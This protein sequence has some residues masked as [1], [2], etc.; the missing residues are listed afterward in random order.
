MCNR[1]VSLCCSYRAAF[2]AGRCCRIPRRNAP[3]GWRG[4]ADH[5]RWGR[6][7]RCP[8]IPGWRRS[9]AWWKPSNSL[10]PT[11]AST[12]VGITGKI[13]TRK[14]TKREKR[15]DQRNLFA[16]ATFSDVKSCVES[17]S[18]WCCLLWDRCAAPAAPVAP[19]HGP[20]AFWTALGS[21][22]FPGGPNS[23]SERGEPHLDPRT[24]QTVVLKKKKK[25]TKWSI[26]I[27]SVLVLQ[28]QHCENR[29]HCVSSYLNVT[30]QKL[31]I[32]FY[33]QS[34]NTPHLYA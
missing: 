2:L 30:N 31:Q 24:T 7:L 21:A 9:A 1:N 22:G 19:A 15:L 29:L 5:R 18:I 27:I 11:Q 32:S 16:H 28:Y 13:A 3:F 8:S 10:P 17:P 6:V 20:R 33:L 12:C 25:I 4:T 34:L 26:Y 23:S 14:M